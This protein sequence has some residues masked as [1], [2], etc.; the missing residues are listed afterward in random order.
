MFVR[1][2]KNKSGV[3]SVQVLEKQ[4]GKT[5]LVK[6]IGS[7]EDPAEIDVLFE[8]G[9]HFILTFGGQQVMT[10]IDESQWVDKYVQSL[11]SLSLVGPELILG[12]I[13][14]ATGQEMKRT[15]AKT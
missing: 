9:H 10:F 12:K 4:E 2:K 7:S 3:I 15:G 1:K 5:V 13:W 14:K 8:K 11:E 6:T